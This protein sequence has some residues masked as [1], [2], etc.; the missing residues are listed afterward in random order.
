MLRDINAEIER[1]EFISIVGPS[2][3]GKTTFLRI[4]AGLEPSSAG[5]VLLDGRA[6]RGPGRRPRL[7]VPEDNLLPWRTVLANAMI[8]PEVAGRAGAREKR[9]TLDLLQARRPCRLRG[10]LPAPALRR[11]APARQSRPRARDRSRRSC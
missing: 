8:G 3:C 7:R 5:E 1:G 10:L 6:V 9:R 11:H 4:V 2:G